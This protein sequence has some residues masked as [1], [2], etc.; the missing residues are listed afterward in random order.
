MK[1]KDTKDR[2]I[3]ACQL[4]RI[5]ELFRTIHKFHD[6]IAKLQDEINE[7]CLNF[8]NKKIT[9]CTLKKKKFYNGN[10]F[11]FIGN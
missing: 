3:I 1:V 7:K 9:A 2:D 11:F 5:N 10:I 8:S 4:I 6:K